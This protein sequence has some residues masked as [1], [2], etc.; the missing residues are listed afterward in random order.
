MT[1]TKLITIPK[2]ISDFPAELKDEYRGEFDRVDLTYLKKNR[3]AVAGFKMEYVNHVKGKPVKFDPKNTKPDDVGLMWSRYLWIKDLCDILGIDSTFDRETVISGK[4][5]LDHYDHLMKHKDELI[6]LFKIK[7][8]K[9]YQ[10]DTYTAYKSFVENIFKSWCG[11][12]FEISNSKRSYDRDT[13]T[14]RLLDRYK[15]DSV[16]KLP[17][18]VSAILGGKGEKVHVH[19]YYLK[20][21]DSNEILHRYKQRWIDSYRQ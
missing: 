19:F 15:V 7:I 6:K 21:V 14:K 18:L 11:V 8:Q 10:L 4:V 5:L 17:P 1:D 2:I 20:L 13:Y 3:W 16:D 12:K 9:N